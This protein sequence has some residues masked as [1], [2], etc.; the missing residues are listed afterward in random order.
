MQ[1]GSCQVPVGGENEE[2]LMGFKVSFWDYENVLGLDR[3]G[4]C[5]TP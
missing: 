2:Q 3:G 1:I 5:T 4:G